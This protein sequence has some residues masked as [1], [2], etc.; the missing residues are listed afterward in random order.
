MDKIYRISNLSFS[1]EEEI[2]VFSAVNIDLPSSEISVIVGKNGAGKTT[3][4][5][6]LTGLTKGYTGSIL[7]DNIE[8]SKQRRGTIIDQVLYVKQDLIGNFMGITPDEDLMIW[9]NRFIEEDNRKKKQDR[10]NALYQLGITHLF[11]KPVWELSYGQKRRSM[12]SVSSLL[13]NKFWILD[14]PTASLDEQGISLLMKLIAEKKETNSGM[15]ILTH[16][17]ELFNKLTNSVYF[18]RESQ[19][20]K[21]SQS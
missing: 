13:A 10:E 4:A 2:N 14:E 5:R 20:I 12:L 15:L 11:N 21:N 16:R 9:Q 6:I 7:L 1:Y 3:L 8:L 19:I 18:I 17:P